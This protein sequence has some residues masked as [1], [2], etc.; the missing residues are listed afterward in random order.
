MPAHEES[1]PDAT[2]AEGAFA[3]FLMEQREGRAP[4]FEELCRRWPRF[5]DDLRRLRSEWERLA[6]VLEQLGPQSAEGDA[7]A[8]SELIAGLTARRS[9]F[10]RYRVEREVGQG[11]MG[12]VVRVRDGELG[13]SLAMKVT[14]STPAR[15]ASSAAEARR[16]G[17]FLAEA[18]VTAQLEHP[19]IVPVHELGVDPEDR[20]YFT[21][22]LVEGRDLDAVFGAIRDGRDEWTQTRALGL[23]LKVCEAV[24]Y[25]HDKGVLH[26]DL[27]P[28][29]VMV[30]SFGEVYVVDWGLSRIEGREDPRDLRLRPAEAE[31]E[32]GESPLRTMEGD[33][34]GTPAFMPPEQA[35][36]ELDRVDRRADVYSIGAILYQ[37]LAGHAPYSP[38]T[39]PPRAVLA[40]LLAGPPEPIRARNPAAPAELEA[41]CEQ[42]MARDPAERYADVSELA[43]DLR[44]YLENRVVRAHRTGALVELRKWVRRNRALAAA[45]ALSILGLATAA[46]LGTYVLSTRGEVRAAEGLARSE[47][48]ERHLEE[49]FLRWREGDPAGGIAV[50]ERALAEV[51]GLPEAIAGIAL[52]RLDLDDP[53]G[54]LAALDRG[55][56]GATEPPGLAR[57]RVDAL[58]RAGRTAEA[59]ELAARIPAPSGP[60]DF[61][62]EGARELARGYAGDPAAFARAA[63]Q[64]ERALRRSLH[65]R[66]LYHF[67][68]AHARGLAPPDG[69]AAEIAATLVTLWPESP[70]AN[71]W[72][73]YVLGFGS[74]AA[75]ASEYFREALRLRPDFAFAAGNLGLALVEAGEPEAGAEALREAIR[76]Q[77]A[78]PE[79]HNNLGIACADRGDVEGAIAAYR[80]ALRLRG[81]YVDAHYNLGN[82]LARSGAPDEAVA[83][84]RRAIE[85]DPSDPDAHR[86]LATA[87]RGLGDAEAALASNRA[88]VRADPDDH[89][90]QYSLASALAAAGD[91]KGAAAAYG[92]AIRIEPRNPYA[93]YNLAGVRMGAGD[94]EAAIEGYRGTLAILPDY[95]EAHC[96]LGHALGRSGRFAEALEELRRGHELGS[97]RPDWPYPSADWLR[98][99]EELGALT[100]RLERVAA[101]EEQPGDPEELMT[102]AHLAYR[103]HDY[104]LSAALYADGFGQEPALAAELQPPHRYNAACSAALA[105]AAAERSPEAR[106]GQ[107]QQA[108][109]WLRAQLDALEASTLEPDALR[110][111]LEHWRRDSDLSTIRDPKPLARLYLG[112]REAWAELW[113]RVDALLADLR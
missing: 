17:R 77:P 43:R 105:A 57:V 83:S 9:A 60:L 18:R 28:A 66:P 61:Y 62:V 50:L 69:R 37:L 91:A 30:G 10:G 65:A 1:R 109:D 25:A 31:A 20:P 74:E 22:R 6:P 76:L 103:T 89:D 68:H 29:N 56:A 71:Y 47:R 95:A 14:S 33:V 111:K 42:A 49:G 113:A 82:A 34:V 58:R 16:L 40:Q 85:L 46:S 51:P 110:A 54:A 87:L 38:P 63:A 78:F 24:G 36:G 8:F 92:E 12:V 7:S 59:E 100:G 106:A 75:R 80:E 19:G 5:G 70:A 99:A 96:N 107:R 32:A 101:G 35:R 3:A 97:R 39:L 93:R 44:A 90:A 55:R 94:L 98:D 45:L 52:A 104:E 26:R 11:G 102:L 41:I 81:D 73:G 53:A 15:A 112:E 23:L 13:R 21:M 79:A 48:A 72:A 88:A 67:E 2:S 64:M 86:A 27:K 108:R 4:D 84:Y